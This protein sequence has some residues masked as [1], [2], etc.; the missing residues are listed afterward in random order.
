ME[1]SIYYHHE[2]LALNGVKLINY[3]FLS[4]FLFVF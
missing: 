3:F 2:V 4:P 1:F